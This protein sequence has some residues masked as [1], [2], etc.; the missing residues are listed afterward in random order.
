MPKNRQSSKPEKTTIIKSHL[1]RE[2]KNTFNCI[3]ITDA[4]SPWDGKKLTPGQCS[5]TWVSGLH[6]PKNY[7]CNPC[8]IKLDIPS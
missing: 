3:P 5:C 7:Y 6:T 2:C 4:I 8:T 1:C